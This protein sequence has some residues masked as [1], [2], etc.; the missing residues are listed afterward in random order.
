MRRTVSGWRRLDSA[1][2]RQQ[3]RCT[4]CPLHPTHSPMPPVAPV[5]RAV[6]PRRSGMLARRASQAAM[7]GGGGGSGAAGARCLA[8][9][10]QQLVSGSALL[11]EVPRAGPRQCE[12]LCARRCKGLARLQLPPITR[13]SRSGQAGRSAAGHLQ[14]RRRSPPAAW[15]RGV[16]SLALW[17][18]SSSHLPY[19]FC[20]NK[21][22]IFKTGKVCEAASGCCAGGGQAGL[23]V[24]QER[25][26]DA[27]C[28]CVR[29]GF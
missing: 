9:W 23:E 11:A 20:V 6:F 22:Q 29:P 13:T 10:A 27:S 5:T 24:Q 4:A 2:I 26:Q 25:R 17:R 19:R 3:R 18:L 12:N 21:D 14:P 15:R 16:P 8:H 7:G 28:S 1:C